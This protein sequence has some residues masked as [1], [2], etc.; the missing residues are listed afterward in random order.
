MMIL[1]KE[2]A[3]A[4]EKRDGDTVIDLTKKTKKTSEAHRL[5]TEHLDCVIDWLHA[6]RFNDTKLR[7]R[8][9][10]LDNKETQCERD[11]RHLAWFLFTCVIGAIVACVGIGV[12]FSFFPIWK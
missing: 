10:E 7:D 4:E 8:F 11:N 3:L 6:S 1:T 9:P 2:E 12:Y 5:M